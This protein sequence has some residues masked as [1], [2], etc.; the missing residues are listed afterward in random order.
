VNDYLTTPYF[1]LKGGGE[2]GKEHE[3]AD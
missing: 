3:R 1:S 2:E